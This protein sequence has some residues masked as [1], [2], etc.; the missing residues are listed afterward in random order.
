MHSPTR[1]KIKDIDKPTEFRKARG[2][3][4]EEEFCKRKVSEKARN[5]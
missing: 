3:S 1:K 2:A 4:G 5:L